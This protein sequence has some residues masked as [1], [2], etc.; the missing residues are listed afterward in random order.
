MANFTQLKQLW[1]PT[2]QVLNVEPGSPAELAGLR[3]TL[4]S[5]QGILLGDEIL[6]VDGKDW[7]DHE[8]ELARKTH[9]LSGILSIFS[10]N[11]IG[12]IEATFR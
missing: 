1:I 8:L 4:Q 10:W 7:A 9:L 5:Q 3:P 12:Y 2:I 6:A 11:M